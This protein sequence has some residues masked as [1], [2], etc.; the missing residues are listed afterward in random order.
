MQFWK[1]S[2]IPALIAGVGGLPVTIGAVTGV[3]IP[4]YPEEAFQ[5][6]ERSLEDAVTILPVTKVLVQTSAFPNIKIDDS[7]TVD[8]VTYRIRDRL[9][10]D[11]GALTAIYLG[12][13][14]GQ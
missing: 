3:G 12:T 1:D 6:P 8:G 10:I 2:D 9:R 14:V 7:I 4:E 11:D 5:S 13:G